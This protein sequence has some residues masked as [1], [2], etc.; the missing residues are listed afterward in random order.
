[1]AAAVAV[2]AD[3]EKASDAAGQSWRA[4]V[5]VTGLLLVGVVAADDGLFAWLAG[6]LDAIPRAAGGCSS[7]GSRWSPPPRRS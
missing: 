3:S 4:F 1:V 2:A 7:P 6:K 5:L